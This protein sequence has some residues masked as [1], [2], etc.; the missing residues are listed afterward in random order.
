MKTI[1]ASKSVRIFGLY[2]ILIPGLVL[3][4]APQLILDLFQLSYG[5]ELW[6]PSMVSFFAM[7]FGIYYFF[8]ARYQLRKLYGVTVVV[9]FIEAAFIIALW[10]IGEVEIG[11]LAFDALGALWTIQEVMTP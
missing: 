7:V 10:L 8:L 9:R 2:L 6:L 3:I 4:F 1:N 11:M 5:E